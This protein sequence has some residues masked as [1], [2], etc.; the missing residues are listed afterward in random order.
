[1]ATAKVASLVL[2]LAF[3]ALTLVGCNPGTAGAMAGVL[4]GIDE[5]KAS[6]SAPARKMMIFGGLDLILFT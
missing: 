1:M 3:V 5:A 6:A 2:A 4:Q